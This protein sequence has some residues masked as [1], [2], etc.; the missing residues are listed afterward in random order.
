M[1]TQFTRSTCFALLEILEHFECSA[2]IPVDI[3]NDIIALEEK[4]TFI[5][6]NG[7]IYC[8]DTDDENDIDLHEIDLL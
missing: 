6:G 5:I 1:K 7:F 3:K 8:I 4:L 2:N